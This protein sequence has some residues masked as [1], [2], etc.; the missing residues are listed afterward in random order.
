[1]QAEMPMRVS[2][3]RINRMDGEHSITPMELNMS[4]SG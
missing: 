4:A 3:L 1:M 2:S